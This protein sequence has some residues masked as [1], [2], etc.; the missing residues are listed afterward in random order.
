[1][2]PFGRYTGRSVYKVDLASYVGNRYYDDEQDM[3][4]IGEDLIYKNQ[5]IGHW[6]GAMVH[7]YD[8]NERSTFYI[9]TVKK[10]P[11]VKTS[12]VHV[13]AKP[14]EVYVEP[15]YYKAVEVASSQPTASVEEILAGVYEWQVC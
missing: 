10:E 15:T 9:K 2:K 6:D 14:T 8:P 7:E 12:E 3:Y 1:M 11:K 13:V 5:I 4:L